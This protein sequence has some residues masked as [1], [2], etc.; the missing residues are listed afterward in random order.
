MAFSI[1]IGLVIYIESTGL[2]LEQVAGGFGS[3]P[4]VVQLHVGLS[5]LT[6]TA[7]VIQI[8]LGLGMIKQKSRVR[9][10]HRRVGW[11]LLICRLG[12]YF[13]SFLVG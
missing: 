7:Y 4:P 5:L 12:N 13:T 3:M 11:M 8:L 1:D 2:V 9:P 10:W 6:L